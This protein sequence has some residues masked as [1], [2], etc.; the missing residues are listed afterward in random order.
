MVARQQVSGLT[1]SASNHRL[2]WINRLDSTLSFWDFASR[3][4]A[5][6]PHTESGGGKKERLSALAVSADKIY[7][8][9]VIR[10][11]L[12][13]IYAADLDT[14]DSAKVL[15]NATKAV[16]SLRVYDTSSQRGSNGCSNIYDNINNNTSSNYNSNSSNNDSCDHICLPRS[17]TERTCACA[18]GFVLFNR[19]ACIPSPPNALLFT[20]AAGISGMGLFPGGAQGGNSTP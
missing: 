18:I 17:D 3:S 9:A 10:E 6:F 15:L 2:Y 16:K 5:T 11:S 7:Y 4:A 12:H 13:R 20:S 8:S 19:T 14:G 1:Y